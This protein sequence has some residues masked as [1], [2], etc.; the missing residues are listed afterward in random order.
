MRHI[1]YAS[2][3]KATSG[4]ENGL[5]PDR[6]QA[7]IWTN[8]G[9]VL[10]KS[11]RTNFCEIWIKVKQ[12]LS[13]KINLK[14]SS[15]NWRLF[16]LDLNV[17]TLSQSQWENLDD[18]CYLTHWNWHKM[19]Y[20]SQKTF[21]YSFSSMKNLSWPTFHWNFSKQSKWQQA[22]FG[23]DIDLATSI[24]W[25]NDGQVFSDAAMMMYMYHSISMSSTTSRQSAMNYM[26]MI[27]E[28]WSWF[29]HGVLRPAYITTMH[30]MAN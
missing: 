18:F 17:L 4:S 5:S 14:I 19:A 7:I 15:S 27:I 28:L 2:V 9:L 11:T 24:I 29:S 21:S 3:K 25:S 1:L 12:F 30:F 20:I 26:T 22:S 6:H 16:F 23:S 8:A 10:I 13:K